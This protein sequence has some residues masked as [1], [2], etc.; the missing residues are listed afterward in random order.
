MSLGIKVF[1]RGSEARERLEKLAAVL[2][3]KSPRH[4]RYYVGETYF[5]YGQDWKW[6]TVLCDTGEGGVTGRYQALN[7]AN[8]EAV[9]ICDGSF[10]R[11]VEVADKVLSGKFCP[12]R[13]KEGA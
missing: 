10:E 1:E 7:P 5:D 6:T 3:L 9:L 11:I 4:F 2:T 12:D 13:I 8:Q